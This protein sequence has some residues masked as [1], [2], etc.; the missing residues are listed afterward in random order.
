VVVQHMACR[1][2]EQS[3]CRVIRVE[4]HEEGHVVT[5]C[6]MCVVSSE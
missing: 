4:A 6:M 3:G 1:P 5:Y 2:V